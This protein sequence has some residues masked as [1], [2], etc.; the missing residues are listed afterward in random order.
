MCANVTVL[1]VGQWSSPV[2]PP[3]NETETDPLQRSEH[4]LQ[5]QSE[6]RMGTGK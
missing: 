5:T 6:T 3:H 4:P 2:Q 1:I